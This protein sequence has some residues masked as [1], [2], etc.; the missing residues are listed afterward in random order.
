MSQSQLISNSVFQKR[1][2]QAIDGA[3]NCRLMFGIGS[4]CHETK[5]RG[6]V[7]YADSVRRVVLMGK[8]NELNDATERLETALKAIEELV[9]A[10][11]TN[12]LTVESLE[13]QL[14][15]L[16]ASLEAERA[17]SDGLSTTNDDVSRRIEAVMESIEGM[18]QDN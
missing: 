5:Y 11:R 9:S 17:R 18:I 2:I 1:F 8:E 12:E 10:K 4:Y 6:V 15:S 14:Q 7:D 13:E 3:I 16:E